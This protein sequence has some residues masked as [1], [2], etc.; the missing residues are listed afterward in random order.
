MKLAN[1]WSIF[2]GLGIVLLVTGLSSFFLG[3]LEQQR[4]LEARRVAQDFSQRLLDRFNETLGAVYLLSSSVDRYSGEIRQFDLQ[5]ADLMRDFPL[6]RAL[7]LAPGGVI[8]HVYPLRGNEQVMGHDLLADKTRNHEVHLAISN[9]KMAIAGPIELRQGGIGVIARY[10]LFRVAS[11]GRNHFWGLS[12]AVLD[13]PLLLRAAN[14][15][16]FDRL[17]YEYQICW[18]TADDSNCK[19][20][21]GSQSQPILDAVR[22]RISVVQTSWSLSVRPRQGWIAPVEYLLVY[23]FAILGSLLVAWG[24]NRAIRSRADAYAS[25]SSPAG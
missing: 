9:R 18:P 10:P 25:L 14:D 21:Q 22:T 4:R 2:S 13:F 11:D 6:L 23:G 8:S 24:A 20:M 15:A 16:E 5:A 12:I 3:N 1:H 7:E 17:G 19:L